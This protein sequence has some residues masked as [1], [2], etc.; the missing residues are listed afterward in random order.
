MTPEKTKS[1]AKGFGYLETLVA[2]TIFIV[3]II[4][5]YGY[6]WDMTG[7]TM[8]TTSTVIAL[9]RARLLS[10]KFQWILSH[11][12][13]GVKSEDAVI[14]DAHYGSLTVKVNSG[15]FTFAMQDAFV[16]T[17]PTDITV[18]RLIGA[19]KDLPMITLSDNKIEGV[20]QGL[21]IEEAEV[22]DG[23]NILRLAAD[24]PMWVRTGAY[25]GE[26]PVSQTLSVE[27]GKL[28]LKTDDGVTVKTS[29]LSESVD[30]FDSAFYYD[31]PAADANENGEIDYPEEDPPGVYC[32][33]GSDE[34]A[35]LEPGVLNHILDT[36]LDGEIS[37]DDVEGDDVPGAELHEPVSFRHAASVRIWLLVR[38]NNAFHQKGDG[39]YLVGRKVLTFND[40]YQRILEVFDVT[41][42]NY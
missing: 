23:K 11:A 10:H 29:I 24:T 35:S 38:G 21:R 8:R 33:D 2:M 16:G 1:N 27:D 32:V 37:W 4:K 26:K 5:I 12:G 19:K 15:Y 42:R 13:L 9:D 14:D 20:E 6:F 34:D 31:P 22:V 28:V 25:V 39:R 3:L 7:T 18:E 36:N 40:D 30:G 17:D 41:V